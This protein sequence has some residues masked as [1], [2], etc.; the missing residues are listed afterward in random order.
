MRLIYDKMFLT[1]SQGLE[2]KTK[3]NICK[4]Y[5]LPEYQIDPVV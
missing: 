2:T 1:S 5:N 3:K 4:A